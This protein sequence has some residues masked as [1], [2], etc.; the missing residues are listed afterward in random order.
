MKI[1]DVKNQICEAQL[2]ANFFV[3]VISVLL[4]TCCL[5]ALNAQAATIDLV[6]SQSQITTGDT[7]S[8]QV[9]INNLGDAMSP[10][11]GDYDVN[12]NYDASL[13]SFAAIN[14]GTQLDLSGF[15]SL[16]NLDTNAVGVLNAFEISFDDAQLL[17]NMQAGSFTLFTLVFNSIAAGT[18]GLHLTI[19]TLGDAFGDSLAVN[20]VNNTQVHVGAAQL[21][22]PS[23]WLLLVGGLAVVVLRNVARTKR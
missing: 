15:G 6:P 19:N 13:L 17:N 16:R 21:P 18:A 9:N 10:S 2:T 20:A 8:L 7:V 4:T 22:E 3:R 23:S 12:L 5:L 1:I 11:L 14:W